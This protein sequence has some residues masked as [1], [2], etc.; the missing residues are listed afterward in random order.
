MNGGCSFI[1]NHAHKG[2]ST[3]SVSIMIPTIADGVRWAPIVIKIKP[4]PNCKNPAKNPKKISLGDI[5]IFSDIRKPINNA[6]TPAT[7]WAGTISTV[8]YFLTTKIKV[9]NDIGIMKAAIFPDI[10]P[11][12]KELPTIKSIPEIARIIEVRVIAEIFSLLMETFQ[13]KINNIQKELDWN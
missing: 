6:K 13:G 3:A 8:G 11:G 12:D 5:I 4:N 1:N 7:N 9:A 10:W 2:P